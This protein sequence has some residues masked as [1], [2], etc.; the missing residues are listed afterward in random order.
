M[1]SI[2]H[3]AECH[4][5]LKCSL[6]SVSPSSIF[7]YLHSAS[8]PCGLCFHSISFDALSNSPLHVSS[9]PVIDIRCVRWICMLSL[10]LMGV[11]GHGKY[12]LLEKCC[13]HHLR[14]NLVEQPLVSYSPMTSRCSDPKSWGENQSCW[15]YPARLCR[16]PESLS[17]VHFWQITNI[18]Q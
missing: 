11:G 13:S 3:F 16:H 17:F 4:L 9:S 1:R 5:L 14:I 18:N 8:S 10:F 15:N 2:L 6:S 12:C 7:F